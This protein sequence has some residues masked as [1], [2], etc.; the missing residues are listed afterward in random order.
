MTKLVKP[1]NRALFVACVVLTGALAGAFVWAFFFLMDAGLG[2]LW[3]DGRLALSSWLNSVAPALSRGPFG[4]ALFPFLICMLGGVVIGLYEKKTGIAA[5]DL[6]DVMAKVKS[7]GR[8]E[9]DHLGKLSI[10]ALLPLL[11]GGSVGPEAGLTGVIAGLCTWVGDRMRRFGS[12]FRELTVL[13][14]QAALTALFTRDILRWMQTP[15]DIFED[16]YSYIFIVFAGT[17]ATVGKLVPGATPMQSGV[18]TASLTLPCGVTVGAIVAVNACGDVYEA[19]TDKVLACGHLA[20]GKP[21]LCDH[22]LY[23]SAPIPEMLKIGI[24]SGQN[25]TIGVVATDAVLTKAQA[26]RMATCAHDG[27]ARTIRPVHTQMDGDTVFALGTGRIDADVN[28]VQLCA[29]AAEVTARAVQ[30]AIWAV[31]HA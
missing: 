4:V 7:T 14:C 2:F 16:A 11:F 8:Y 24:P 21:G 6:P 18:G 10:A 23:G 3:N 27:Y 25:T 30:N 5:E 31:Q 9:Y 26:L 13:G 28:P 17:G 1:A 19:N 22:L 12:D 20:D 29:A 15:A